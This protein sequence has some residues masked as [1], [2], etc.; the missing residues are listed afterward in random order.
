MSYTP[1][2]ASSADFNFVDSGYQPIS[3]DFNFIMEVISKYYILAGATNNFSAIWAD[4]DASLDTGKIYVASSAAFSIIDL[5]Q[6][7]LVDW[8]TTSH[9]GACNEVLNSDDIVDLHI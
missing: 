2:S 1:P 5:T 8:Y 9:K 4:V 3:T 7:K 6:S